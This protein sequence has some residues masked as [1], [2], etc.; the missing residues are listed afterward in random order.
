MKYD[1]ETTKIW[2]LLYRRQ[3]AWSKIKNATPKRKSV[4]SQFQHFLFMIS[5]KNFRIDVNNKWEQERLVKVYA[6][7]TLP[8]KSRV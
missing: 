5:S 3:G 2:K 7:L 6:T 8:Y 4:S 1:I